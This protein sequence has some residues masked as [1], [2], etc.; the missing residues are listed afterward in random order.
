MA[1][2]GAQRVEVHDGDI[3]PVA[4]D[5]GGLSVT[6][7]QGVLFGFGILLA[8]AGVLD[9]AL[10]GRYDLHIV[11]DAAGAFTFPVT[12]VYFWW[13]AAALT[14]AVLG[15]VFLGGYWVHHMRV[16]RSTP[17]A[18]LCLLG[19]TVITGFVALDDLRH[20]MAV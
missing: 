3:P 6:A 16:H 14:V 18:T 5:G 17:P 19:A 10:V 9:Y 8:C 13:P 4:T 12:V 2:R 1:L 15:A 20:R 11:L 7:A